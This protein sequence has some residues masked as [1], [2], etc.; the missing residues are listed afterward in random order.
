MSTAQLKRICRA[1]SGAGFPHSVQ[2]I[3]DEPIPFFKVG[4]LQH[5]DTFGQLLQ[6]ENTISAQTAKEL[7]AELIPP[8]SILMAKIGAA[9]LLQKVRQNRTKCCIDNNMMALVPATNTEPRYLFYL[10]CA[11]ELRPHMNPGAVPNLN[12]SSF[13]N[14]RVPVFGGCEQ[15][16]IADYLDHETAEIDAFIADLRGA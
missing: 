1:I 3:S 13:L 15:Q 9:T 10:L 6:P 12:V 14:S 4:S 16:Q 11:I 5:A 2:G 8:Q 7:G